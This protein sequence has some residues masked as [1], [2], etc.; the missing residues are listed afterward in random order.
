VI[1][2]T[3]SAKADLGGAWE[4]QAARW[5]AWA[6]AEGHDS[7]WLF[8]R[9]AFLDLVPPPG[10]RTLELGCGE[11]RLCRDLKALGHDMVGV[12]LSPTLVAAAREADPAIE[13]H[14]ADAAALPFADGAFDCV[15][16]FMSLQD[17]EDLRGAVSEAA[18][19]L[20]RSGRLCVAIVHP[21]NSAGQ[22]AGEEA[23]SPFVIDGSYLDSSY[24]ADD[25]ERD[26]LALTFVSAHRPLETY[27][28]ALA[29]AGFL[30]ERVLEPPVPEAAY[31]TERA[32]RWT[33]IPLFLYVRAV[34][35]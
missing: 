12:D 13:V 23:D 33:R 15:V 6:R 29:D 25:I 34:K 7:Y 19:V 28:D 24:Y 31:K 2:R 32:R 18:R 5:V 14:E 22:F 27:A 21:L 20:E 8:N 1:R 11:G 30:I 17:V 26:G 35:A 10:R 16:A 9:D 4:E 3:R